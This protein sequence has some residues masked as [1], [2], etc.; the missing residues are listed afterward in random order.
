MNFT[1]RQSDVLQFIRDY[2]H[3]HGIAP[4]LQEIGDTM[5]ISRTSAYEHIVKLAAKKIVRYS[6]YLARSIEI[7]GD[8]R[9]KV[10]LRFPVLGAID[11]SGI[12]WKDQNETKRNC[13]RPENQRPD[14]AVVRRGAGTT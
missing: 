13:N 1:P 3:R 8:V 5:G 12:K 9:Q 14:L 11:R 10:N 6:R 7:V 4:T 2:R